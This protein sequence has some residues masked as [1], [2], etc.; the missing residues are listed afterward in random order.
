MSFIEDSNATD[1]FD[2]TEVV[3]G[4]KDDKSNKAKVTATGSVYNNLRD[5]LGNPLGTQ[6][7][8]IFIDGSAEVLSPLPSLVVTKTKVLPANSSDTTIT[9]VSTKTALKEFHVGG[10]GD[11]E[12]YIARYAPTGSEIITGFNSI[13]QVAAWTNTSAGSS[14]T[15]SWT[16]VT[17]QFTEGTGSAKLTFTQS[18]GNNY[19]EISFIY[20]TPKDFSSWQRVTAKVRTTVATGGSQSRTVSIRLTSGTAIRIYSLTGTTTTSPFNVEQWHTLDFNI[21]SPSSVAGT[22][23]F[24]IYNVDRISLR[25]QDGGN[26]SGSIWWDDVK[27]IGAIDIIQ[28]IYTTGQT[29]QLVFDPVVIFEAG[30]QLYLKLQNN[31][32]TSIECQISTSG[33]DIT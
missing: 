20:S 21:D 32:T 18:D 12:G 33:V 25:L 14:L 26:K 4:D 15:P 16:Y 3:I 17:D 9:T 29:T 31:S 2:R 1:Q 10:R 24:D 6:D 28:K 27:L 11:C 30:D 13:A 8:P 23:T 7:N 5:T 19:P 22:G